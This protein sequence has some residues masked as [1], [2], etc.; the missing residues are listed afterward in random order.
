MPKSYAE[1]M[2]E[3]CAHTRRHMNTYN[4][5]VLNIPHEHDAFYNSLMGRLASCTR[6]V[7]INSGSTLNMYAVTLGEEDMLIVRLSLD[8]V[9][10][11][12]TRDI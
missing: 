11:L 2:H 3:N 12:T 5:Y 8:I 6:N 7:L 10:L 4:Y 1:I 9:V